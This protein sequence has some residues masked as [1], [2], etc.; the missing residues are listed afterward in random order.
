MSRI[1]KLFL[2]IM[3]YL[4]VAVYPVSCRS[5]PDENAVYIH[6]MCELENE[7]GTFS[8]E[9]SPFFNSGIFDDLKIGDTI[10][11]EDV[12]RF[13]E[14]LEVDENIKYTIEK[15]QIMG[16]GEQKDIT[17]PYTVQN[18]DKLTYLWGI[19][20]AA[21]FRVVVNIDNLGETA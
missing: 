9:Y 3:V 19:R 21:H 20:G 4:D 18:E 5:N 7:D 10:T 13:F 1:L 14:Y 11:N 16:H 12:T 17:L 2:A 6:V 8:Y 15:Y